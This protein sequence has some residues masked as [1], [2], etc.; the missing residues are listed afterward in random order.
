MTDF[1]EIFAEHR[2]MAILRGFT[3]ERT[4]ELATV[5]WNAGIELVEVPIGRPEEVASLAATVAAGGERGKTVGAGTV[6]TPEQVDRAAE[7]G[8]R[9]T[10]APGLDTDVAVASAAAGM[11]HLPG[12]SG[13]TEIQRALAVGCGWVKVFPATVVGTAWFTA[14][15][16]PFPDVQMVATGGITVTTAPDYLAAGARVVAVGSA[17]SD[18]N[19]VE[20]LRRLVAL[21]R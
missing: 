15:R 3:P 19:Q 9:Y 17:L 12:V 4:V 13:A 5:A 14:M 11:P 21:S 2:I 7:A 18:P 20:A 16:G 6:I 8:A 1:T 10:V